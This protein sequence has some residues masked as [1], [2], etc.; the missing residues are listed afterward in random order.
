MADGGVI[1][2]GVKVAYRI[3][4]SPL[5]AWNEVG[6]VLNI[7]GF[8]LMRDKV[9]TTIHSTNVFKR[10]AP[11]MCEVGDLVLELLANRDEGDGEGVVQQALIDL[12]SAGTTV[13]WRIEIPVNRAQTE[14]KGYEFDGYIVGITPFD[15]PIE[16]RQTLQV[17]V[18]FDD[19]SITFDTAGASEIAA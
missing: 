6:Q 19:Q 2:N 15:A 10:S 9:N 7:S 16:D 13:N 1:G 12:W 3:V 14:F 17:T 5:A 4:D 18:A 11:G 8:D